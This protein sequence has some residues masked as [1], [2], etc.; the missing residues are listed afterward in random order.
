MSY[1]KKFGIITILF[2]ISLFLLSHEKALAN[3]H[4]GN[5]IYLKNNVTIVVNGKKVTFNA[6]IVNK[7]GSLFLPMR[8][9]YEII[10]AT[11]NWDKKTLTA[12]AVKDGSR[13]D[14]TLNS[15]KAKVNGNTVSVNVAP[16]IY[17]NRTYVPIRF[18]SENFGGDVIWNSKSQRVDIAF[19]DHPQTG[20]EIQDP[21]YLHINNKRIVMSDPILSKLGRSYIPAEYFYENLENSSGKWI[22]DQQF[23]LQ[24]SGLIF[25]FT[26]G[27]NTVLV[28]NETV[29][30]DEKP[31]KQSGKMYVPVHFIVNAFGPGGNLR[32]L[33]KQKEMYIYL[34][35][36]MF[37]SEFLEK[38]FG[39]TKV[40]QATPNAGL[41][42][43]RTLLVSDNPESLTPNLISNSTATLSQQKVQSTGALNE[44]RVFGWHHNNL[45]R[46]IV[47][48]ITIE[49]TSTTTSLK[50]TKSEGVFKTSGNSW[51]N[52]DIGLPIADRVLNDKLNQSVSTGITIGPGETKIIE[53]YDLYNTYIIGFLHDLDI[54]P[55]NG[56]ESNYIIRTVLSKNNE[57]LAAVHSEPVPVNP[58]A[59]HPRGVWSSS[60]IQSEFPTYTIGTSEVG[61]S[62]SNGKTDNLLNK[63]S[64]M[65]H[66]NGVMGNSGHFGV[67]YLVNIPI[68]NPTGQ[69]QKVKLKLSG[70]GGFYSGAIKINGQVYLIPTLRPGTEYLELPGQLVE[71][72]SEVI[73]LEIMHAGG[74]NLPLAIY[75]ESE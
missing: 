48:G 72:S 21:F 71:G 30:I 39:S 45:G 37:T 55:I 15:K 14:V 23:E 52:Y 32:Y 3:Q 13:V 62:I 63:E 31:F 70:R 9:F 7:S 8:D 50:V 59:P 26:N 11:V 57:D 24:V 69:A 25:V 19:A 28:N 17:K 49:N 58:Q 53:S 2:T 75:V 22:S 40:P 66:P 34:Y 27:S 12:S 46:D 6:P 4:V 43:N 73:S 51:I 42:G 29:I 60:T 10:G 61:Y 38:S 41:T 64:S 33:E 1:I 44:H 54:Q 56:N 16:F 47:L 5:G 65:Q 18:L 35:E 20:S 68:D 74:S 36:Y 67:N